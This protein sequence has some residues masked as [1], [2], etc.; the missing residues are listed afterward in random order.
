[1]LC[2]LTK[3]RVAVDRSLREAERSTLVEYPILG[4]NA[5]ENAIGCTATIKT[6]MMRSC[7]SLLIVGEAVVYGK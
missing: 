5:V 3:K 6:D 7:A 1:M 4:L 2:F